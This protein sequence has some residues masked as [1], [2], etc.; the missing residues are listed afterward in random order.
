M[1]RPPAESTTPFILQLTA[2]AGAKSLSYGRGAAGSGRRTSIT[3][4]RAFAGGAA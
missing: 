3:N 1:K 4:S 2:T